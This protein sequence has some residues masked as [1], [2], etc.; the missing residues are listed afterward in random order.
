MDMEHIRVERT[1]L[2]DRRLDEKIQNVSS[3]AAEADDGHQIIH[4][5]G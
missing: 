1:N 3:R 5:L 4:E 2:S